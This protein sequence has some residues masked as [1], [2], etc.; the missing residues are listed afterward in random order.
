MIKINL[1]Q[2]CE[3][4]LKKKAEYLLQSKKRA[5]TSSKFRK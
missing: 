4:V 2:H 3:I 1:F 5:K